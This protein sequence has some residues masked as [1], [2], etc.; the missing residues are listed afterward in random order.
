MVSDVD[1]NKFLNN[2]QYAD[3]GQRTPKMGYRKNVKFVYLI[4]FSFLPDAI[5]RIAVGL[6]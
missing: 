1:N 6:E 3:T 5:A 4:F 2:I